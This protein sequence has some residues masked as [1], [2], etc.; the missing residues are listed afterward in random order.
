MKKIRNLKAIRWIGRKH[1]ALCAF[2]LNSF[3]NTCRGSIIVSFFVSVCLMT[4]MIH[5]SLPAIPWA[6]CVVI[7]AAL[8]V[9]AAEL[10]G[11]MVRLLFG[12]KKR[13]RIY[14]FLQFISIMLCCIMAQSEHIM[15]GLIFSLAAAFILGLLG[16][17]L[18][19]LIRRRRHTVLVIAC[20]TLS[21]AGLTAMLV[22][23][24][25]EGFEKSYIDD[26]LVMAERQ[27][28][29][30][31]D[32]LSLGYAGAGE[33]ETASLTYGTAQGRDIQSEVFDLS[34][35]ASQGAIDRFNRNIVLGSDLS[36]APLEGKIWYPQG[37]KHCPVM[38]II[39][40]NHAYTVDSYLGYEYLGEYLAG[41]GYVVVSVN[42]NICNGLTNENDARAVLLLENM[43]YL[44]NLNRDESSTIYQMIDEEQIAVA[45]HSRGGEAVSEAYLFNGYDS[46]PENGNIRFSY[47]FP[48]KSIIAIAP[49]IDQYVPAQHGVALEDV[50]YFIIHGADDQDV[51]SAMGQKQYY[52]VSFTGEGEYIK[53]MLYVSG[54]NHG[55]FNTLWGRY[56]SSYPVSPFLNVAHFLEE[57]DQQ[58]ILKLFVKTFLDVTLKNDRSNERLLRECQLYED[59]LPA[60]VC[61]QMYQTSD[62]ICLADFEQ[63]SDLNTATI[64]GGRIETSG[65]SEWTEELIVFGMANTKENYVM[66]IG[67]EDTGEAQV[68]LIMP[69]Q[70]VTDRSIVFDLAD[71]CE[72]KGAVLID[73][74]VTLEDASGNRASVRISDRT[75]VYPA[76]PVQRSK[77]DF[78]FGDYVYMHPF[79]T[80]T[81]PAA[82]FLQANGDIETEHIVK[83]TVTFD[84]S[85]RG[86]VRLDHIGIE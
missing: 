66:K 35:F 8:I 21:A 76:L 72:E 74:V 5:M 52:N 40:G 27:G 26:Y 50:N 9:L 38:F 43:R 53:T 4:G 31:A 42:E 70:D 83:L 1:K 80:V 10:L 49:S 12:I 57:E 84:Y 2:F 13:N 79:Q 51:T 39:H 37:Q 23:L 7:T 14:W 6:L 25:G 48:I 63:D 30:E 36:N 58:S 86:S 33:Y 73:G 61:Q 71:A 78:V 46:Y 45:G 82:A 20:L 29:N 19:A 59:D 3:E 54:A 16:R 34:A 64:P 67:W 62:F 69:Q 60:T 15:S 68:R 81:I 32:K 75:V 11:L 85:D 17:C 18:Y 24:G 55:Q 47:H 41:F 28:G 77:L 22:L 65:L 56:D 44:L